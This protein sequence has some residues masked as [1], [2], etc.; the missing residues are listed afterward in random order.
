MDIVY[1]RGL[2]VQAII[3]IHPH[4]RVTPQPVVVD[5]EMAWD[6]A[7][8]V[9]GDAIEHT[10]DY[11][12]VSERVAELIQQGQYRLV[13]TLAEAIACLLREEFS[14]GWARIR[15]GKPQALSDASEVG[16]LIERGVR[17]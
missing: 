1:V 17:P 10:L 6:I 7:A 16:V 15:V 12:R 14:V 8:A 4:E 5:L 13:E 11:Q 2:R 3:G 9:R